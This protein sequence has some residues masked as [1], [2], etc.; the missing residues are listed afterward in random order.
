MSA[1][2]ELAPWLILV[3]VIVICE[4]G[5]ALRSARKMLAATKADLAGTAATL[6][7]V[8]ADRDHADASL[9]RVCAAV[10]KQVRP[11]PATDQTGQPFA[12]D[13]WKPESKP[14]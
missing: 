4:L 3:L 13:A 14:S 1:V 5:K 10:E 7:R 12:L 9:R 11:L 6:A 8:R 2:A